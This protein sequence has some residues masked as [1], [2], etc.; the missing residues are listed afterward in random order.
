MKKKDWG[1][2]A[3]RLEP[4]KLWLNCVGTY[5]LASAGYWWSRMAAAVIIRLFY[6]LVAGRG[7][8]EALLFADDIMMLASRAAEIVDLGALLFIWVAF[9]LPF[10]WR[11]FRGGHEVE[12]IGYWMSLETFQL[13]I[14][15]KRAAWLKDWVDKVVGQG[16]VEM[17]DFSAVLGR[18]CFVMGALEYLR[19]F[20]APLFAWAAAVGHSGKM[21]I[22]WSVAF[23][24]KYLMEA[25]EGDGR[26][27]KVRPRSS[28]IGP[29]FRADA[30]AEGQL[31]CIGG[32][33]CLGGCPPGMARWF[34]VVLTRKTAP[35]AF[36]RGEPFRT[37]A[38]LELFASLVSVLVFSP[39]W[40]RS[41]TGTVVLSG[42][43]DNAG[44]E[45]VLARLMSSKFPLVV[46]LTELAAQLKGEVLTSHFNGF[47]GG[48]M[49][50]PTP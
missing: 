7:E 14:S 35:W 24:L 15:A 4:G 46:I 18:L 16:F 12:W 1:F 5:G 23:L 22:P 17:R 32:W 2:Q 20:T 37:I 27:A 39:S 13:G 31:V 29:A 26:A 38:A 44:N 34:S 28:S 33:E 41:T 25:L 48:R 9:G 19:P 10:K 30:K 8:Q 36:S 21:K 49:R 43:T 50:R 40:P 45:A 47:H 42:L 6:Y 3:C 11:K